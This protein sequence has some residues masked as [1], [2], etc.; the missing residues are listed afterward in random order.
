VT[1]LHGS[2]EATA[3]QTAISSQLSIYRAEN[4]I[5]SSIVCD[6][7]KAFG[8]LKDWCDNL[9]VRSNPQVQINMYQ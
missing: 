1:D 5:I 6:G 3:V 9:G 7:E 8:K 2:R 4:Y